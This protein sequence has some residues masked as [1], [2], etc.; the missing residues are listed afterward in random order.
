MNRVAAGWGRHG[1]QEGVIDVAAAVFPDSGDGAPGD[2]LPGD[3][4]EM[5]HGLFYA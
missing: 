3:G 4:E 2:K 5:L 1:H